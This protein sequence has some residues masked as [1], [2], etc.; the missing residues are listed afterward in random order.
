MTQWNKA[1][2][3]NPVRTSVRFP[4]ELDVCLETAEGS[5]QAKTINVSATGLLFEADRVPEVGSRVVFTMAMPAAV[6]GSEQDLSVH[7]VGRIVRH[8]SQVG[9]PAAAAVIDEYS[10]RA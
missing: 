7:C 1:G 5:I 8:H 2:G 6:M 3:E 4:L 10:L 9:R